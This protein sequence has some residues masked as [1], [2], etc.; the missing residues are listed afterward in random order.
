MRDD[1]LESGGSV[2]SGVPGLIVLLL[3]CFALASAPEV[4]FQG[5]VQGGLAIDGSG[6][7]TDA[8]GGADW[9][10]GP[11]F[12]LMI[13]NAATITDA[14]LI[15]SSKNEGFIGTEPGSVRVN[16]V[17]LGLAPLVVE[18]TR[19][20][21]Y[22]LD[23][24][25]F[26][27]RADR[28]V[29]YE[30][31]ASAEESFGD[32]WGVSGA[33]LAVLYEA[34]TLPAHRHVT[35]LAG[36]GSAAGTDFTIGGLDAAYPGPDLVL[37]AGLDWECAEEQDGVVTVND[38][39]VGLG[40]GGRDDGDAP[41]L[42]C[43]GDWNSLWT[44]GSFGAD[45]AGVLVGADG[46]D[47]D[48]EPSEGSSINS[49]LSD[50]LWRAPY[51]GS[52]TFQFGYSSPTADSWLSVIVVSIDLDHDADGVVDAID[53]CTDL[54]G[55]GFG[56]PEFPSDCPPDCDDADAR[57][58]PPVGYADVDADGF[59]SDVVY[60][61]EPRDDYVASSGDCDDSDASV[62]PDGIEVCD[63]QGRDEDCDTLV[64][65]DDADVVGQSVWYADNDGDGFGWKPAPKLACFVPLAHVVDST[66]CD[67]SDATTFPGGVEVNG[68]DIDQDCDGHDGSVGTSGVPSEPLKVC[69]EECGCG[70][71]ENA[72]AGALGGMLAVAWSR[73]RVDRRTAGGPHAPGA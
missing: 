68:D 31:S 59:G 38:V 12:A 55:D 69:G 60:A 28:D 18:G 30:E 72:T 1:A 71:A 2:R 11:G 65:D 24:L 10:A 52:D 25:T 66:D 37:S 17:V 44:V 40:A 70:G 32:S 51:D 7:G 29:S 36:Y 54:D 43:R 6:V 39:A 26:G 62:N 5:T 14:W 47:P 15:L 9:F 27:I 13:P 23:P 3:P 45:P 58:G 56:D 49:R 48:T 63:E 34:E 46:D 50:E 8:N 20:A 61:C 22:Q 33:T 19:F 53:P 57:V 4:V 16:G 67:D 73:R 42:T 21:V 35:L 64:N 41:E